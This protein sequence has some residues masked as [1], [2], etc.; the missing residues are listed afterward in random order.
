MNASLVGILFVDGLTH[1][2]IYMQL[3]V[4]CVL[5][6]SVTRIAFIALGQ[7]VASGTVDCGL[8]AGRVPAHSG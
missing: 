5:I 7:F 6:I 2:V 8:H 3:A 1:G 4:A